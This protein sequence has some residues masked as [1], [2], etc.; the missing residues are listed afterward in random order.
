MNNTRN[1]N[2]ESWKRNTELGC[3]VKT[4]LR[5]DRHMKTGKAYQGVLT[6]DSDAITEEYISRDPHLTF[7]ETIPQIA[8]RNPRVFDGEFVTITR[9][10]DGTLRP[11]LK[12]MRV[13]RY[14]SVDDYAIRVMGELRR[15]L[16]GLVER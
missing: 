6:R 4:I 1:A 12:P 15:A 16:K 10:D 2:I 5:S 14:F 8:K 3:D 7:V 9:H 13:D 11:N